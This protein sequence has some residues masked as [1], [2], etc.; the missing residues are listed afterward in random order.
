MAIRNP[1]SVARSRA[2]LDPERGTQEQSDLEWLVNVVPY[3]RQVRERPFVVADFDLFMADPAAQ[4]QRI[5]RGLELPVTAEVQA[6]VK[7]FG[8]EFL[9]P[10]LRHS[11]HGADD[12]DRDTR[13]NDLTRT[14]YRWL[15]RLAIDG[16]DPASAGDLAGLAADRGAG[17]RAGAGTPPSRPRRRQPALRALEPARAA[18]IDSLALARAEAPVA[19][20]LSSAGGGERVSA[21]TAAATRR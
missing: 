14:A 17:E 21:A 16:V 18:A 5:A 13:I 12:L 10:G 7:A 15:Y 3:F 9:D 8:D 4:L 19:G 6:S 20:A 11:R 1:L 2:Q